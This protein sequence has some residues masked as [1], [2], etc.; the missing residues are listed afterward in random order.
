MRKWLCEFLLKWLSKHEAKQDLATREPALGITLGPKVGK[1]SPRVG[2]ES[3]S[4]MQ[5]AIFSAVGGRV[6]EFRRY[7]ECENDVKLYVIPSDQDFGISLSKIVT[8]E[9]LR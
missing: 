7:T 2:L 1:Y 8:L 5:L 9:S 6:V 4:T 3:D